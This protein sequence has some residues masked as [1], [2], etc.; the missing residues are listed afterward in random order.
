MIQVDPAHR[1][2]ASRYLEEFESLV[3]PDYFSAFLHPVVSEVSRL[4]SAIGNEA[5][6]A[7]AKIEFL[8][9]RYPQIAEILG[10]PVNMV[11]GVTENQLIGSFLNLFLAESHY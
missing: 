9:E 3:F 1:M 7:D 8:S 2:S 11:G 4:H 6:Q 5:A 10:L